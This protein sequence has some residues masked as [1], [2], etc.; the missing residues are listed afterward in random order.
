[1]DA[2]SATLKNT[3]RL[4]GLLYLLWIATGMYA[5]DNGSEVATNER[6]YS[7]RGIK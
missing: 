1:M 2:N 5:F 6:E 4:S 7:I 3:A